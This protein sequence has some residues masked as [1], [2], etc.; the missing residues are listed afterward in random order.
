[1]TN[2][3]THQ[4]I[5]DLAHTLPTDQLGQVSLADLRDALGR[6]PQGEINR[7]LRDLA[8]NREIDLVPEINPKILTPRE[9]AAAIHLGG[10]D[11]HYLTIPR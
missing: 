1:M 3:T 4:Y 7:V 10:E 5:F 2:P 8:T 6:L 9:R 11:H